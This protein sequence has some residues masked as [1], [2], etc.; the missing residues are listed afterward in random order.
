MKS[1]GIQEVIR[2]IHVAGRA[3]GLKIM[4]GCMIEKGSVA[5]PAAAHLTPL[6]RLRRPGRQPPDRQ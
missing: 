3:L 1:G 6:D 5:I 2:M 4:L